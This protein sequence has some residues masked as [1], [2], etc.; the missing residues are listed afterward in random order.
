MIERTIGQ[1]DADAARDQA[2]EILDARPY[3][4]T[5]LPRPF[6]GF[7]EWLGERLGPLSD[8]WDAIAD[9]V[10]DGP[11][12]ARLLALALI[13]G[14]LAAVAR[15]IALGRAGAHLGARPRRAHDAEGSLDP[16][17]LERLADAAERDGDLDRALRLRFRAGLLRLDRVG[18]I[19]FRPSITSG[20]V[21]RALQLAP[22]DR[23]ALRHDEVVYG[24]RP[25]THD[26]VA[27]ARTTFPTLVRPTR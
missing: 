21:S 16:G 10:A 12:G 26:D 24:G 3:R 5:E 15:R 14:V 7:L 23:L 4:E 25:A 9:W 13:A 22:F 8:A 27:D 1:T 6:A 11:L 2:R 17:R 20:E 19:E 18:L